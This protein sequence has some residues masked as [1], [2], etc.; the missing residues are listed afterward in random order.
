MKH[1]R[2]MKKKLFAGKVNIIN[3]HDSGITNVKI[4][5][6]LGLHTTMFRVSFPYSD[7]SAIYTCYASQLRQQ[8]RLKTSYEKFWQH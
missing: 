1:P 3:S 4:S 5:R 7:I 8:F 2:K 6:D